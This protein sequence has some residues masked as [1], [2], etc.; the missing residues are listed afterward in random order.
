M[1]EPLLSS[2]I[3][4]RYAHQHLPGSAVRSRFS[5]LDPPESPKLEHDE[6]PAEFGD[7]SF[8]SSMS[9]GSSFDLSRLP[10]GPATATASTHAR[11][12]SSGSALTATSSRPASRPL[13]AVFTTAPA[14]AS[15]SPCGTS[16][17]EL[18][19]ASIRGNYRRSPPRGNLDGLG[20]AMG[21]VLNSKTPGL[22][23]K[24]S[25]PQPMDISPLPARYAA[26]ISSATPSKTQSRAAN[27]DSSPL[28]ASHSDEQ[29]PPGSA[30]KEDTP[31][32]KQMYRASRSMDRRTASEDG[33]AM[34]GAGGSLARL[35][36]TELSQN[37]GR[38]QA[39][40]KT[41]VD[42]VFGNVEKVQTAGDSEVSES[43]DKEPPAKRRPSSLPLAQ[44]HSRP[45]LR[46]AGMGPCL[47]SSAIP[48]RRP[49][50]LK[51]MTTGTT[52]EEAARKAPTDVLRQQHRASEPLIQTVSSVGFGRP[53]RLRAGSLE[54][55]GEGGRER[56]QKT[57]LPPPL[58]PTI[59]ESPSP[60]KLEDEFA[61]YFFD[62]QSPEALRHAANKGRSSERASSASGS[63]SRQSLT[64]ATLAAHSGPARP[65]MM[66]KAAS[67]AVLPAMY[68]SSLGKRSNPY[69]KRTSLN[70]SANTSSSS[71]NNS[72]A[73]P[74]APR[75]KPA[76]PRR[77][78]SALDNSAAFQLGEDMSMSSADGSNIY[79]EE[80]PSAAGRKMVNRPEMRFPPGFD[81]SGSPVASGSRPSSRPN[82][83][84]RPS[85]DDSS[86]LGYGKRFDA[87]AGGTEDS[88]H[89][90]RP[91]ADS[92]MPG[93]GASER[94]GKIL[95]CFNVKD[96]GLMRITSE[97]M[98]SVLDGRFNHLMEGFEVVD[99]R[100]GY[101]YEGGHILGA[102]NLS[103]LENVK[104]HFLQPSGGNKLPPRSQSGRTDANG[105]MKKKVL[106]FHCEFSQKRGPSSALALRQADRALA[107]DY[108]NCHYPELYVLEGGYARFF[109]QHASACEPRCYIQM[110]DPKYQQSRSRDLNGFRKQFSRHRSFTYGDSGSAAGRSEKSDSS[111]LKPP[112]DSSTS[113]ISGRLAAAVKRTSI[114]EEDS[115]FENSTSPSVMQADTANARRRG[116]QRHL[117]AGVEHLS[118]SDMRSGSTHGNRLGDYHLPPK[119]S[120]SSAMNPPCAP[121][122]STAV[123][124]SPA[125]S[126]GHRPVLGSHGAFTGDLSFGSSFGGAGGAVG[127]DSS[128]FEASGICES[129]CAAVQGRNARSTQAPQW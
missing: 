67:S 25:S 3:G 120:F 11:R 38:T 115:S 65:R 46:N 34:M 118:G 85:K 91:S 15:T 100:F 42:C 4:D 108:P 32:A 6:L 99:C 54:R 30:M 70:S 83:F 114:R 43:P 55:G 51:S 27:F 53:G 78:Q 117:T 35:F 1:A 84:R 5:A 40:R 80:S 113:G 61:G 64:G 72:M 18:Y 37:E 31:E 41:S 69:A 73:G 98:Q 52:C 60:S 71:S 107:H 22:A 74:S 125:S 2:P 77:C 109:E 56:P 7:Q 36:G 88:S 8:G 63:S 23:A 57:S 116:L 94:E 29:L 93:F 76:A 20:A 127:D 101:E 17:A 79:A 13:S 81:A 102:V 68:S 124:P 95:P 16:R 103:T 14:S 129:P 89:L 10:Q 75:R 111:Y 126:L 92:N 82:L 90:R 33:A 122:S 39:E 96:D 110:D 12:P 49:N 123:P 106:I 87:T 21:T 19:Q 26:Q 86:P 97:T 50:L 119:S 104:R 62:P 45:S 24:M 121:I 105:E 44:A 58:H 128:S 47:S 28:I 66:E 112:Q 59:I 9:L 48:G